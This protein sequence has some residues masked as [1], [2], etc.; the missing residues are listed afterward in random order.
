M[1]T[2]PQLIKLLKSVNN[3][4]KNIEDSSE[5]KLQIW[6]KIA[7]DLSDDELKNII[8][9]AIKY[10]IDALSISNTTISRPKIY[11]QKINFMT[12]VYQVV[13]YLIYQLKC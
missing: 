9:S 12:E 2:S 5:K 3:E 1:Q 6:L 7:P 10:N 4:R 11:N 13:H 8:D